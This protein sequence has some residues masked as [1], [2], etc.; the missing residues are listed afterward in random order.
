MLKRI[1]RAISVSEFTAKDFV[2]HYGFPEDRVIPIPNG[3]EG[4]GF[5][6]IERGAARAKL[7]SELGV[8][9]DAL[10]IV[11]VGSLSSEKR[12]ADLVE[13][14]VAL[15]S[16]YGAIHLV[17]V[18]AGPLKGE[19]E[20]IAREGGA[21]DRVHFLGARD[22]VPAILRGADVFAFTSS[23]E[24]MP[25]VLIEAGMAGLPTVVYGVGAVGEVVQDCETG[26]VVENGDSKQFRKKIVKLIESPDL[27]RIMGEHARDL[28]Q[29][30]FEIAKIAKQYQDVFV[31]LVDPESS[32]GTD[33]IASTN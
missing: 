8:G 6:N 23:S 1:S 16:V 3:V 30:R 9:D 14:V 2:N 17:L 27:R 7:R 22:D 13:S 31:D 29:Q 4:A 15:K 5:A 21:G 26:F 24:G 18:G 10:L 28:C 25:A 19:L 11:S 20:L 33:S 12:P 32:V